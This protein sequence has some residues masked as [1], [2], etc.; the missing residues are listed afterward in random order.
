MVIAHLRRPR[1]ASMW[2]YERGA[3]AVALYLRS[4]ASSASS[5]RCSFSYHDSCNGSI[6]D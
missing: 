5:H 2:S 6:Q 3:A 1:P 4:Y